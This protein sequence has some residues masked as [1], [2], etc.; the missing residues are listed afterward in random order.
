MNIE[1]KAAALVSEDLIKIASSVEWTEKE[2]NIIVTRGSYSGRVSVGQL[3]NGSSIESYNVV[4]DNYN[5]KWPDWF[6][7]VSVVNSI[8]LRAKKLKI[9]SFASTVA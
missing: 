3:S 7:V 1:S 6:A 5:G 4:I 2:V 8:V 9:P